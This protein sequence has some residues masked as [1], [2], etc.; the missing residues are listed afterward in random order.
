LSLSEHM[1][2]AGK[3]ALLVASMVVLVTGLLLGYHVVI[4]DRRPGPAQEATVTPTGNE[5]EP[6][7]PAAEV[8]LERSEPSREDEGTQ[9]DAVGADEPQTADRPVASKAQVES[10]SIPDSNGPGE[11]TPA[12]VAEQSE[13][14]P[15]QDANDSVGPME[16]KDAVAGQDANGTSDSAMPPVA[17]ALGS[18]DGQATPDGS[19]T[20]PAAE[21]N[22]IESKR[23]AAELYLQADELL[24]RH[25]I[26]GH[27]PM[28]LASDRAAA[29]DQVEQLLRR[30]Q[31][32]DPNHAPCRDAMSA[33]DAWK[34]SRRHPPSLLLS[35]LPERPTAV[36]YADVKALRMW[37]GLADM[38]DAWIDSPEVTGATAGLRDTLKALAVRPLG[39]CDS[40]CL[41]MVQDP[42]RGGQLCCLGHTRLDWQSLSQAVA[43]SFKT[44]TALDNSLGFGSYVLENC[45]DGVVAWGSE[46]LVCLLTGSQ[47]PESASARAG[48]IRLWDVV[49]EP[50]EAGD[51]WLAAVQPFAASHAKVLRACGLTDSDIVEAVC[52]VAR[53]EDQN[54]LVTV[55]ISLIEVADSEATAQRL[56]RSIEDMAADSQKPTSALHRQAVA[57]AQK[58]AIVPGDRRVQC[59]LH[60]SSDQFR[61]L[62]D[63]VDR[64][65]R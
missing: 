2:Y 37:P 8:A 7:G 62:L 43:A 15:A 22:G 60:L 16:L 6:E 63:S 36:A 14:Q 29:L 13:Q 51:V 42:L 52:I 47:P 24:R 46:R 10:A 44:R 57:L 4:K 64:R 20:V 65:R 59:H 58:I 35:K 54:L 1:R 32:L 41:W 33:V 11:T 26:S 25:R 23:S 31:E 18:D 21:P 30:V 3:P 40:L 45:G 28:R 53:C 12:T 38:V 55:T 17:A 39:A 50:T 61:A 27:P 48:S 19:Q 34:Q 56:R 9:D 5:I 49:S